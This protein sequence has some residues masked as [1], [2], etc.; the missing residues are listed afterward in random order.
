VWQWGNARNLD[1]EEAASMKIAVS[2]KGGVG[3]TTLVALLARLLQQR[4]KQVIVIDA[5]PDANLGSALGIPDAEQI[6][7]IVNLKELIAERTGAGPE[8]YGK[9]FK[10]N[11]HVSDI[12]DRYARD[13]D[14]VKLLV[15]GAVQTG[16]GGCA[17]PESVFLKSLLM[18]LVVRR[19]EAVIVDM[20][21][22]I[23]PLG[24][25]TVGSVDALLVVVEPSRRSVETAERVRKLAAEIGLNNVWI[26][27]NRIQNDEE[28]TFL[29]EQLRNFRVLGF[30]PFDES[31]PVSDRA[32]TGAFS[33]GSPSAQAAEDVL[34][35][36]ES[37]V[38]TRGRE[39]R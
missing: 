39:E 1:P 2:G 24:R 9:F 11:P 34:N 18:H 19:D 14:G 8:S 30:V 35:Q 26:V 7:P 29:Q 4:G 32:G 6:E 36:L 33:P 16:G 38:S 23:E 25:A 21:A 22:G 17:C 3:K 20:E 37:A 13:A 27:G 15:L 28:K 10:L 31:L 12:P 5:D